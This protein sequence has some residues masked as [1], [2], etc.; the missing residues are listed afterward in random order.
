VYTLYFVMLPICL[1]KEHKESHAFLSSFLWMNFHLYCTLLTLLSPWSPFDF[2][3]HRVHQTLWDAIDPIC[4]MDHG[5][6]DRGICLLPNMPLPCWDSAHSS[7][8]LPSAWWIV[9]VSIVE[10]ASYQLFIHSVIFIDCVVPVF[11]FVYNDSFSTH[12]IYYTC[13]SWRGILLCC[14]PE[15][16]FPFFPREGLFGSFSWSDV[17]FWDWDVYVYRL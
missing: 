2:T 4:L 17:R 8:L 16:F 3:S 11:W 15:G 10:Y 7:T 14:S 5:G 6:L 13:P 12:G 1:T 9:E